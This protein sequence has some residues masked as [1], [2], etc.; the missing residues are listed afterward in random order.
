MKIYKELAK[1]YDE[2]L[3]RCQGADIICTG[4]FGLKQKWQEL[5]NVFISLPFVG[6][7]WFDPDITEKK[8]ITVVNSPGCNKEAVAE[9][10]IGM[11]INLF[12]DLPR[13]I[14][15]LD[16]STLPT[17]SL[18]GKKVCIV[19]AGNIG[20]MV[21]E[22]C[23]TL[24]MTVVYFKRGDSLLEKVENADVIVDTIALNKDTKGMYD[25]IFFN[26]LKK[27]SYFITVT[28]QKLWDVDAMIEAL[29]KGILAGVANDCGSIHTDDTRAPLYKKLLAH[30]HVLVTAHT[31]F[32]TDRRDIMCNKMMIDN[33][34]NRINGKYVQK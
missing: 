7:G 21:G 28:S 2:W 22:I 16:V 5:S 3:E 17:G 10:I 9:W 23:L 30:P 4:K 6:M 11:M 25:H 1:T 8:D 15:A 34:E 31:A 33:I 29:D 12:R 27:G 18:A 32:N 13:K 24:H 14:N 20:K 19:G 26:S